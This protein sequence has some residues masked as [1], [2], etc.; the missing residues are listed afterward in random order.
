MVG[1]A[2]TVGVSVGV[3]LGVEV[4]FGSWVGLG[5]GVNG[6]I[7]AT[8]VGDNTSQGRAM[9]PRSEYSVG[10]NGPSPE[11]GGGLVRKTTSSYWVSR[12][13]SFPV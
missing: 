13:A 3:A 5:P 4:E 8:T 7:V 11:K 12:L 6:S 1:V 9:P 2:V 10:A